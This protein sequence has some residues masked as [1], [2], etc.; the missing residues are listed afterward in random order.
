MATEM[1]PQTTQGSQFTSCY[2][3]RNAFPAGAS[4]MHLAFSY[5][6]GLPH[7]EVQQSVSEGLGVIRIDLQGLPPY[8]G[9]AR[10]LRRRIARLQG[11]FG[12]RVAR[13]AF[14]P[15]GSS[16][17][18]K[19]VL[20]GAARE[21]WPEDY[22]ERLRL[23]SPALLKTLQNNR[24]PR[25]AVTSRM[26]GTALYYGP[27]RS[28]V[29]AEHFEEGLLD[30]FRIRRCSE[31]LEPSAGH[32]GCVFGEIGKCMR[33]CQ[34]AV[35]DEEYR[36]EFG[37]LLQALESGGKSLAGELERQRNAAS[38]QLHFEAAKGLHDKALA[39]RK[40]FVASPEAAD[41]DHWH[42]LIVQKGAARSSIAL[43]PVYSGCLQPKIELQLQLAEA[44]SLDQRLR[45]ALENAAFQRGA[46]SAQEDS[47]AI[48]SRWLF[49]SWK[50]GEFLRIESFERVPY[51]KLVNAVSRVSQGRR[52][53]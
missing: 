11:L 49:S 19:V 34:Q 41:L 38:E 26:R 9:Q 30:F 43:L 37:R 24:F 48:V 23:R 39:A 13:I 28:R 4:R 46:L 50:D 32:T 47:M 3:T 15:A 7:D 52:R 1:R 35:T 16:F 51:R 18:A 5:P 31:N 10:N 8:V 29:F 2:L 20:W 22:R 33:P 6:L 36:A 14:Q 27:F 44:G 42:G 25:I 21:A 40:L 53:G 12:D 45:E 17:E